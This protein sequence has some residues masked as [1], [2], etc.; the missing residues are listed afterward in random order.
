MHRTTT[1]PSRSTRIA[2]IVS[3]RWPLQ[4]RSL[5]WQA[6]HM[7]PLG[8]EGRPDGSGGRVG[9]WV[10]MAPYNS[11]TPGARFITRAR[12]VWIAFS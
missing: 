11:T 6:M 2:G 4:S 8:R 7:E 9:Y 3:K 1:V 12:V 10:M 5:K